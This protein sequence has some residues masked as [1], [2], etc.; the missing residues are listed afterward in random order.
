VVQARL[1]EV[2]ADRRDEEIA[3]IAERA[4]AG[5]AAGDDGDD[6][7]AETRS[8]GTADAEAVDQATA[9]EMIKLAID[10][11]CPAESDRVDEF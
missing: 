1:P 3:A 2:A 10:T 7:V 5:L 9:R 8:L 4:C 6:I 11:V